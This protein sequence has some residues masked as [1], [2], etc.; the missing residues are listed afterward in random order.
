MI[1]THNLHHIISPDHV[2]HFEDN[3]QGSFRKIELYYDSPSYDGGNWVMDGSL[4]NSPTTNCPLSEVSSIS[5]PLCSSVFGV[6]EFNNENSVSLFPNSADGWVTLSSKDLPIR[7]VVIYDLVGSAVG[8][9]QSNSNAVALDMGH[10]ESGLY[11]ISIKL[12][13]GTS[14]SLSAIKSN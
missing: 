10:L 14:I 12:S 3:T 5:V 11:V 8:Q 13:N 2:M 4:Q 7:S 6:E 1:E 9:S